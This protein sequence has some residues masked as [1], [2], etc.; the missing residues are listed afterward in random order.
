MPSACTLPSAV[1]VLHLAHL[2]MGAMLRYDRAANQPGV[3]ANASAMRIGIEEEFRSSVIAASKTLLKTVAVW[4]V[5]T[6]KDAIA[7]RGILWNAKVRNKRV[8]MAPDGD[9]FDERCAS[10]LLVHLT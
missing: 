2:S 4:M 8:A 9:T 1:P 3:T 7:G 6:D 10:L 5:S